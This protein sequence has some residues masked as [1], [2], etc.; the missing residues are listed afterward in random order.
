MNVR[1][2]NNF[3]INNS[4]LC[5]NTTSIG[6]TNQYQYHI[7]E[8][9]NRCLK[10]SAANNGYDQFERHTICNKGDL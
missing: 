9:E 1:Q 2:L 7:K 4:W 6:P 8:N 5:K 3:L 10:Q